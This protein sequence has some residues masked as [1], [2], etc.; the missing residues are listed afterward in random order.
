MLAQRVEKVP[1]SM[2]NRQ[3]DGVELMESV[4]SIADSDL[5]KESHEAITNGKQ[6]KL[7]GVE[8]PLF[9]AITQGSPLQ[10]DV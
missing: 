5:V 10:Y 7:E 6:G 9:E 8:G 1:R 3:M 4:N 2:K